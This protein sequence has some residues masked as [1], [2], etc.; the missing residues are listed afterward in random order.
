MKRATLFQVAREGWFVLVPL[1]A[2]V[3]VAQAVWGWWAALPVA[4]VFAL[5]VLFFRDP[6]CRVAAEPLVIIVPVD[7]VVTH[8][9]EGYDPFLDREAI[10][11]SIR[12]NMLG[13][14]YLRSP[15]EGT[16]LELE[17]EGGDTRNGRASWMRTDEGDDIVL[18]I[19]EGRLFGARPCRGSPGTR[20]GQGRCCGV[21]RLARLIDIYLPRNSRVVV[22]PGDE[23]RAGASALAKLVHKAGS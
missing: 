15:V 2:L 9:R 16:L 11:I 20:I 12:V 22:E 3:F 1:V 18:T 6:P 5:A 17:D 8:R 21:R 10:K 13:A 14:Y 4:A 7:G 19:S 23:V